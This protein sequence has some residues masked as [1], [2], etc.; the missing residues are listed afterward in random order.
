MKKLFSLIILFSIIN[1]LSA[2]DSLRLT[3]KLEGFKEKD[4]LGIEFSEGRFKLP[5]ERNEFTITRK[6]KSPESMAVFYKSR[7]HSFWMDNNDITVTISKSG[8]KKGIEVEGSPA[9]DLWQ[10]I[11]QAPKGERANILE[12]NI[13]TKMAQAYLAG[14]SNRLLPEDKDRLLTMSKPKTNDLAKYSVRMAYNVSNKLKEG[15]QMF[16]FTA[17]TI[18]DNEI[19]TETLRGKYILL[20]F[21]GTNCG[22]CWVE[23][24]EMSKQLVKYKNLHALTLNLDFNHPQWQKIAEKKNIEL[25]WPV[26]WKAENKQEIFNRY[27]VNVLPTYYLISPEGIVLE[28]WQAGKVEKLIRKL[29]RYDI[30]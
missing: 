19:S 6:L 22:W 12:E 15:D 2:Q 18:E 4:L 26:L 9:E 5:T 25:P 3:I 23:Y 28:K 10:K 7:F 1:S 14:N 8:F 13:N 17:S 11:V 16:D 21:A 29:E 27:G 20:D 30:N 24:P